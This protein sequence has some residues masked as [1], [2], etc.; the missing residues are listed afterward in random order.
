MTWVRRV[1][2]ARERRGARERGFEVALGLAEEPPPQRSVRSSAE[3]R[4]ARC[5]AG[6]RIEVLDL[7]TSRGLARCGSCGHAWSVVYDR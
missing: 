5:D 3:L 4:C 6:A 7:R 2:Q 1:R